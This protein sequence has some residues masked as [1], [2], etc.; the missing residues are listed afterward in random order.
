MIIDWDALE[1]QILPNFQGGEGEFC[2]KIYQDENNKILT[3]LL[4]PGCSIG[5]H[6]HEKTSET[7]F[8]VA[9]QGTV[10]TQKGSHPLEAGQCH[11]CPKGQSHSLIN[12][13]DAPLLFYAVVPVHA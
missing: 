2:A 9:G 10:V 8:L 7:I 6:C 3:G 12:D 11:Y 5:M 13:S 4:A 1:A